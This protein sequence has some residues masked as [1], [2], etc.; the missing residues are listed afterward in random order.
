M[1]YLFASKGQEADVLD[2]ANYVFSQ[3]HRPHDFRAL[4]PKVYARNDF[5][6]LH[7]IAMEEGRIRGMAALLPQEIRVLPGRTLQSG[8]VGTV[9]VHPYDRGRGIMQRVM[10]ML[11][12]QGRDM[13]LDVLLL[14]GRRHRYNYFGYERGGA[15]VVYT[16]NQDCLHHA[17]KQVVG[18]QVSL[19]PLAQAAPGDIDAAYRF[20]EGMPMAAYRSREEFLAVLGSVYAAPWLVKQG[21]AVAGYINV[22]GKGVIT[23]AAIPEKLWLPVLKQWLQTHGG[24]VRVVLPQHAVQAISILHPIAENVAISDSVMLNILNWPKV[25]ETVLAF[26]NT[27]CPLR[28]NQE[29]L[30]V[31][32]EGRWLLEVSQGQISAAQTTLAPDVSMTANQAVSL[33]FSPL[34]L[35]KLE[36]RSFANW[37]PLPFNLPEADC[38]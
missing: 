21:D 1:E 30:D 34:S 37:L 11:Y 13:E 25:L 15:E 20:Y 23:E 29:V 14:G 9:G 32:G 12:Q 33:L 16:I 4:L 24:D 10:D 18:E 2:F 27:W 6:P 22:S 31:Q 5:A 3:A 26:K 28:D 36:G 8:F 38:F 17:L 19:T 7:A 35:F